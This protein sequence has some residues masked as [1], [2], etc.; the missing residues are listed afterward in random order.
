MSKGLLKRKHFRDLV[1]RKKE[2]ERKKGDSWPGRNEPVK[3]KCW[4][5]SPQKSGKAKERKKKE[6]G[7]V[8]WAKNLR[9]D[10]IQRLLSGERILRAYSTYI[11]PEVSSFV[12]SGGLSSTSGK[13]CESVAKG[14]R[15][16]TG[17]HRLSHTAFVLR[18][19]VR[20]I[21]IISTEEAACLCTLGRGGKVQVACGAWALRIPAHLAPPPWLSLSWRL[22]PH[23]FLFLANYRGCVLVDFCLCKCRC[24]PDVYPVSLNSPVSKYDLSY[25]RRILL[26]CNPAI[27]S[28]PLHCN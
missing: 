19:G 1:T 15:G 11:Q 26:I 14:L 8:L 20:G 18:S 3:Q 10:E 6:N 23:L 25:F 28:R 27:V 9:C 16:W 13:G 12:R 7:K 17:N 4:S 22:K 5:K 21:G 2:R 24:L